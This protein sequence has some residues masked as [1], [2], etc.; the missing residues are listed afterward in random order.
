MDLAA[1]GEL[2]PVGRFDRVLDKVLFVLVLVAGAGMALHTA[3]LLVEFWLPIP[4]ADS[5]VDW[6]RIQEHGYRVSDLLVPHEEH[7][8]AVPRVFYWIDFRLFSGA[9]KFLLLMNYLLAVSIP[10]I[11]AWVGRRFFRRPG[12]R[13][14]YLAVL[15]A[16][17]IN[18]VQMLNLMWSFM[19]QHWLEYTASLGVACTFAALL[20]TTSTRSRVLLHA[21]L[22]ALMLVAMF[23]TGGGILCVLLV[24][25]LSVVYRAGWKTS[26]WFTLLAIAMVWAYMKLNHSASPDRVKTLLA[27][28]LDAVKFFLAFLGSPY[29]RYHTWPAKGLFWFFDGR[30]ALGMGTLVVVSGVWVVVREWVQRRRDLFSVFHVFMILLAFGIAALATVAR[31]KE[32]VYYATVTKYACASLL[33]WMSI[34]SLAVRQLADGRGPLP[35]AFRAPVWA[36]AMLAVLAVALPAHLREE[37]IFRQHAL[38]LWECESSMVAGV[39]DANRLPIDA[40]FAEKAFHVVQDYLRPRR[41]G[42]FS[43]YPWK[44]GD[45]LSDHYRVVKS[46][47][48]GCVDERIKTGS[49]FGPG[50]FLR[51]WAWDPKRKRVPFDIILTDDAG[52]IVGVAHNTEERCDVMA[53]YGDRRSLS[54]GWIGYTKP[55]EPKQTIHAYA[56]LRRHRV[57]EIGTR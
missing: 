55:V 32:G 26:A 1:S 17:Y 56:V 14:M 37:K 48:V 50:V 46:D 3:R 9:S 24:L 30:L 5:F 57:C 44:L 6:F 54:S 27:A 36:A 10:L 35:T 43:R 11:Y 47:V 53:V 29:L 28:K 33:A 34:A 2:R 4:W 13:W 45:S 23:S 51:G 38:S 22:V 20:N 7:V 18:G 8:L 49:D 21:A 12:D 42:P 16:A 15:L 31:L 19:I 39:Y 41:L 40:Y 52:H 25:A